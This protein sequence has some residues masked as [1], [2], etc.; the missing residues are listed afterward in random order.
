[1]NLRSHKISIP[2]ILESGPNTLDK[3]GYL[4]N[5]E[6]FNNV[7]IFYDPHMKDILNKRIENNL[8]K[9]NIKYRI[10]TVKSI[11]YSRL[12]ENA[13]EIPF[14]VDVIIAIGGGKVID[15]AKYMSFLRKL[16]FISIPTSTS[17]DG[18]S[19]PVSSVYIKNKRTTVPAK[20][21]YG[22]IVDTSIIAKA[23]SCF[24]YSGIGDVISNITALWDWKYEEKNEV[25]YL[26]D[27]S[28]MISKK[29][30]D[31]ILTLPFKS[32]EEPQFIQ[33]LVDSLIMNGVAM[34]ISGT[35]KPSSGSEHMISHALDKILK[36]PYLHGI[37]VGIATY[38]ISKLQ[39]NRTDEIKNILYKTGFLD[40]AKTLN[41]KSKY[42]IEAIDLAPSIKSRRY[43]VLHEKE[44]IMKAKEIVEK[45]KL[46]KEILI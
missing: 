18:F 39:N 1:M 30:I 33:S 15:V 31:S 11:D 42:F 26:E 4:L 22:I 24:I 23:P 8:I 29:S 12:T 28:V 5:R 14:D 45:D 7:A 27:F 43:T 6:K 44:N 36:E 19:S 37:Q 25:D 3:I 35:S 2:S 16:P 17:N 13:F 46:L 40:Y 38:I 10:H 41:I 9:Y 32:I 20:V 34:E 21:P